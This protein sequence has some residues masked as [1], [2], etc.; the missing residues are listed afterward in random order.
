MSWRER[1]AVARSEAVFAGT[2]SNLIRQAKRCD[3]VDVVLPTKE[4]ADQFTI[5][6][7]SVDHTRR[8]AH[9]VF[10]VRPLASADIA[11]AKDVAGR[12]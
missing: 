4:Q 5:E 9:V 6:V 2:V 10:D 7:V 1:M 8:I 11:W 3:A 12:L